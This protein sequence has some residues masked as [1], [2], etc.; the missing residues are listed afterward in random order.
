MNGLRRV[1]SCILGILLLFFVPILY[2]SFN[3][4]VLNEQI[5]LQESNLFL[6]NASKQGRITDSM[7]SAYIKQISHNHSY[8][9]RLTHTKWSMEPEYQFTTLDKIPVFTGNVLSYTVDVTMEEILQT[10]KEQGEYTLSRGDELYLVTKNQ[11]E[12]LAEQLFQLIGLK[13]QFPI[14]CE[15][16]IRVRD[17]SQI[18]SDRR[19][20]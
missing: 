14:Q 2:C 16:M 19:K 20:S 9:V 3:Q 1:G 11:T 6:E 8:E 13:T 7:L 18:E 15:V 17:E 10:L 4:E 5:L 12:T